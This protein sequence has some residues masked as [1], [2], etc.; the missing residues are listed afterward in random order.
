MVLHTGDIG[1]K[2]RRFCDLM[3]LLVMSLLTGDKSAEMALLKIGRCRAEGAI[4]GGPSFRA[5]EMM[6]TE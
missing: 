5:P 4:G 2:D 6:I 1:G 3:K